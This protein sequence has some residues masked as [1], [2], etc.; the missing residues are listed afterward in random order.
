[1]NKQEFLTALSE[2]LCNLAEE[3][4]EKSVE[5]YSEMID[6]RI[7]DGLSEEE[8]VAAMGSVDEIASRILLDTPLPK[9]VKAKVKSKRTL[10]VWEIILLV[11]GS[12]IWLS[13]MIAAL[14]VLLALF[15]VMW[16]VAAVLYSVVLSFA[17]SA[18]GCVIGAVFTAVTSSFAGGVLLIGAALI[19]AA[20]A[21]LLFCGTF[22]VVKGFVFLSKMPVRGIK[23]LFIGRE[24]A[25]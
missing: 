10:G 6:D 19:C 1:M 9:L 18:V 4:R 17:V 22:Y 8:A 21:I 15:I 13:L 24:S 20:L 2:K 7:E 14:A 5:Y 3:D 16:T 12:P 25:K 23:Q 11:L